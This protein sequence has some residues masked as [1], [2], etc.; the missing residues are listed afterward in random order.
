[1]G[2][3]ER[4]DAEVMHNVDCTR[5]G[6]D[7]RFQGKGGKFGAVYYNFPHAGAVRGF[8]DGHPF[9]QWRHA[10]L[11]RLFFRALRGFVKMGGSVK[12]A[13]NSR[14]TGVRFSDII[15]GA[16]ASEFTHNE[17]FPFLEWRLSG[18]R[19][20]YGDR[21]DAVKRPEEGEVYNDQRG[22]SDMVYCF[23]TLQAAS[24]CRQHR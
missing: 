5:L 13:S 7:P 23:H 18:Y 1:M 11:M 10:N 19:R 24:S 6:V 9:V 14:A 16:K 22:H 3:L 8:F 2:E 4:N 15:E 20:S 21:R 12:V 17:T